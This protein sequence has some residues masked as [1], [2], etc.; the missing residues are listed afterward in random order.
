MIS[1]DTNCSVASLD[2][3]VPLSFS[4]CLYFIFYC[5]IAG[6]PPPTI[7]WLENGK[8]IPSLTLETSSY[9]KE[10]NSMLTVKQLNR[11]SQHSVYSCVASNFEHSHVVTDVTLD[12]YCKYISI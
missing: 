12:L 1:F 5:C 4:Y 11:S 8:P 9:S 10:L 7:E 2:Y 3:V 6:Q